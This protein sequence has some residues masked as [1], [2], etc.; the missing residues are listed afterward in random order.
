[1]RERTLEALLVAS[2]N[3]ELPIVCDAS[4]CTEGLLQ[5]IA[6]GDSQ[7]RLVIIDA[8]E[9]VSRRVLPFLPDV[10]RLE[11]LA[12]HPTCSSTRLGTNDALKEIAHAVAETV[13]VPDAWGCCAFAGDRGMLHPELTAS[14]TS[15]QADEVRA[16]KATAHASCNR[17]CEL[18][19]T[20]A[21]GEPYAHVIELLADAHRQ[22]PGENRNEH[23]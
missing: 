6:D 14:A 10:A 13:L 19:M 17:T 2:R 1:M 5:T 22:L 12:L 11:S 4:S 16:M 21:T 15:V 9:F 3:G 8:V 23:S 18:G 7:H 20:R